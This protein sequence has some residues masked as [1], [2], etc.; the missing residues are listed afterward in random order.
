MS[1]NNANLEEQNAYWK[2]IILNVNTQNLIKILSPL[3]YKLISFSVFSESPGIINKIVFLNTTNNLTKKP[4][5]M[6]LKLRSPVEFK[7][8]NVTESEVSIMKYIKKHT[9]I[10]VPDVIN[11][12]THKNNPF[13]CGY[14]L[15]EKV[16]GKSLDIHLK[17]NPDVDF[18]ETL[19][20]DTIDIIKQLRSIKLN[21]CPKIGRFDLNMNIV[22]C[23][24]HETTSDTYLEFVNKSL[25]ISIN[26]AKKIKNFHQLAERLNECRLE[27]NEKVKFDSRTN[28]LN[29]DDEFHVIHGD[30]N[31]SNVL[32][33]PYTWKIVSVLDWE[34][35]CY[36]VEPS[37]LKFF[38]SWFNEYKYKER[39]CGLF[40]KKLNSMDW[41][42]KPTGENVRKYLSKLLF[43]A[44]YTTRIRSIWLE[45]LNISV[46]EHL[47]NHASKVF[48]MIKEDNWSAFLIQI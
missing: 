48:E 25:E 7:I 35:S 38:K 46:R 10:P 14:I 24:E 19:I 31:A 23:S 30:F 39:L 1:L 41:Y 42:K 33:D 12:C 8:D 29:Y 16:K 37:E 15:M 11:F 9:T 17:D 6:V 26:E 36:S 40:E 20:D 4:Y 34:W 28:Y 47:V 3:N 43:E 18:P 21:T 44:D 32:I 2:E 22:P 13:K 27:L 45:H 5:E